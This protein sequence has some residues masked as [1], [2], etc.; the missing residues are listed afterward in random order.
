M[1]K[2]EEKPMICSKCKYLKQSEPEDEK[3]WAKCEAT[4]EQLNPFELCYST[5][6]GKHCPYHHVDS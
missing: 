5:G 4:E 2:Q 1:D 3:L 6:I